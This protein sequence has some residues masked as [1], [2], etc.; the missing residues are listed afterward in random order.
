M[1]C[2]RFELY[3][4]ITERCINFKKEEKEKGIRRG[5]GWVGEEMEGTRS[6]TF[7]STKNK[8]KNKIK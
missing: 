8:N 4:F 6:T 1:T 7:S 2:P 5:M 3:K